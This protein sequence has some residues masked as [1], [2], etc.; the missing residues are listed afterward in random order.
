MSE[1][2]YIELRCRS[3]FSFLRGGSLPEQLA[4]D[5]PNLGLSTMALL[6]R[7]GVY[8]APRFFFGT[9]PASCAVGAGLLALNCF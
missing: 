7:D 9:T 3:A 6:D 1:P 5:A 4:E 8:G 2:D